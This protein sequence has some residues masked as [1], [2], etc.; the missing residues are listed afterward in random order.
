MK[1]WDINNNSS[2]A[3]TEFVVSESAELALQHVLNYPN[4]FTTHT[5]FMFEHN[6]PGVGMWVQVQVFTVTGKLIKTLDKY[7]VNE[8]FRNFSLE[9]D[10]TDDFGDRIGRGVYIYRLKVR[11][12]DGE[13]AHQFER[14]VV[15]K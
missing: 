4:P 6:K 13:T 3:S 1:V 11:T 9:W 5:T 15:L 8:G 2:K 7:L 10:G 12:A 14:L